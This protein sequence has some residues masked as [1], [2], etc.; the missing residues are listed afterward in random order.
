MLVIC[1]NVLI[2]PSYGEVIVIAHGLE[3]IFSVGLSGELQV[4]KS[5][6]FFGVARPWL[7]QTGA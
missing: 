1:K 4:D 6:L 7:H 3:E 2:L 5:L